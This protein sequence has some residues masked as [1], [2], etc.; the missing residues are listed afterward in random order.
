MAIPESV[1]DLGK[2]VFYNDTALESVSI[3]SSVTSIP[4]ASFFRC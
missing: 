1:T 3:P 2:G 4:Y